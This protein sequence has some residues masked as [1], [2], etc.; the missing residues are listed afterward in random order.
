MSQTMLFVPLL[1]VGFH[2][3]KIKRSNDADLQRPISKHC[4]RS[5]VTPSPLLHP[6]RLL[7]DQMMI[8]AAVQ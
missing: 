2:A 7:D 1:T 8:S 4:W 3:D 5:L 6:S